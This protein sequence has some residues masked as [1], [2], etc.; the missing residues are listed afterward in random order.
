LIAIAAF[1][2]KNGAVACAL[3]P[4]EEFG[5]FYRQVFKVVSEFRTQYKRV[6]GEHLL[7][8]VDH[9][10]ELHPKDA[11]LYK[12][13]FASVYS[14]KDTANVEYV[15]RRAGDFVSYR[16]TKKAIEHS[17]DLIGE[18]SPESVGKVHSVWHHA[19]K[20]SYGVRDSGLLLSNKRRLL[21]FLDSPDDMAIPTGIAQLDAARGYPKKKALHMLLANYGKGKSFWLIHMLKQCVV[22]RR[23]CY[24]IS[25]EM[26]EEEVCERLVCSVFGYSARRQTHKYFRID[27]TTDGKVLDLEAMKVDAPGYLHPEDQAELYKLV[28]IFERRPPCVIKAYPSNRFTMDMLRADLDILESQEGFVPDAVIADY[29]KIFKV[30]DAKDATNELGRI[31]VD[32]RGEAQDRNYAA[33]SVG[34]LNRTGEDEEIAT[35]KNIGIAYSQCQDADV[36]LTYN[37]TKAEKNLG[38]ARMWVD[39]V[40]GGDS[41]IL[42]LLTQNYG[43]AQFCLDSARMSDYSTKDLIKGLEH[44]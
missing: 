8:E 31:T 35:G 7:D 32:F 10:C 9:L 5:L 17:I 37:Q 36:I 34:Q 29:L 30:D 28:E 4:V 38:V 16:R 15:M 3:V 21:G 18:N 11:D 14:L 20:E 42:L 39:K 19:M 27:K 40:R 26:S 24:Y 22:N 6:I 23:R 33:L 13:I 44:V 2:E 41:N 1:D 25:L 43:R 12:G